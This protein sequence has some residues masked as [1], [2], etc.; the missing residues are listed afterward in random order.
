M[1]APLV[2]VLMPNHNGARFIAESIRSVLA[3]TFEDYELL[4]VEDAST[5]NSLQIIQEFRDPRIRVLQ[6]EQ[7][8]H[9]CVGLNRGLQEAKGKY[10]AR[11]DSDDCWCAT[12]L[13]KQ[14]VYM[15]N[16][17]T[18]GACFTWVNVVDEENRPLSAKES[19]FV[20]LFRAKNRSRVQWIHDF[21]MYGSCLCHPSAVFPR[22]V[23]EEL[24]GYRN[25]LVQ[26][27]DFDLWIRIA[28]RFE[29][30][31]LEEPLM[32]Y[33]HALQ[34]GNVSATTPENNVRSYYEM[35]N[36]ISTY[37]DD[38]SD[39]NFREAF[40]REFT[41]PEAITH[42]ELQ[43]ERMLLLLKPIFCG[44]VGKIRG[45]DMLASLLDREGTR[46]LLREQYG[47]T[48]MD[49]YQLSKSNV[50]LLEAPEDALYQLQSACL[51]DGITHEKIAAQL[52]WKGL[53]KA[54]LRKA[55][56]RWPKLYD[57]TKRTY[58]RFK[59]R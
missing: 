12:K 54:I 31:V 11:I 32:N 47:I 50:L 43:C 40:E 4:I 38:L 19:I 57:A 41:R 18:C 10:I 26:I 51:A 36:V 16:H 45:M 49:F 52:S 3:Q 56:R 17:P 37:F 53:I 6:L 13:E 21:Y 5:D 1:K 33:R 7:N 48:Q 27:Q 46:L 59:R 55:L 39:H 28:K 29:L 35:Y 20:D 44:H 23:I 15:E 42:E 14:I 22:A 24:G 8:E 9:I 25:S 30:H 34:G 58:R 2:T